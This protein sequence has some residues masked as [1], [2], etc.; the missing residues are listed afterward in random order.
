[1]K[2]IDLNGVVRKLSL[3]VRKRQE[4]EITGPDLGKSLGGE[5]GREEVKIVALGVGH[6]G[7]STA[8]SRAGSGALTFVLMKYLLAN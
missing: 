1:M 4:D 5:R 7:L 2:G 3:E 8:R 6:G